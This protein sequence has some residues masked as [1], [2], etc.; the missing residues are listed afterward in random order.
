MKTQMTVNDLCKKT[1]I[2]YATA[3]GLVKVMLV[4]GIAN[5]HSKRKT[6]TGKGKP[7]IVYEIPDEFTINLN[8]L[9]ENVKKM[10]E[11]DKNGEESPA[12]EEAA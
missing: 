2:E 11:S 5:V 6:L 9:A 8:S 12:A 10:M 3:M 7:S 1:G 4:L